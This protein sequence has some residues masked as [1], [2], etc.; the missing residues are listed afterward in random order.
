MKYPLVIFFVLITMGSSAQF[1]KHSLTTKTDSIYSKILKENRMVWIHLPEKASPDQRYPVI[2]VLD[3]DAQTFFIL[4]ALEKNA[5]RD[6]K[7]PQYIVIGIGNISS[8]ERDYTPTHITSSSYMDAASLKNSGGGKQFISFMEKELI[9]YVEA[10]YK[11]SQK[12]ILVG[13]SLGGLAVIDVL[14][15]HTGLF[16]QYIAIDPSLW[17]DNSKLLQQAQTTLAKNNFKD[18]T[19]YLGLSNSLSTRESLAKMKSSNGEKYG[20]VRPGLL[21][22]DHLDSNRQNN[23]RYKWKYYNNHNHASV[24][25]PAVTEALQFI[26]Q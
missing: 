25:T 8:R 4:D 6:A 1:S 17:W 7:F 18:V 14:L 3:G 22:T 26:N 15:N 10:K 16:N 11:V 9:P 5:G 12:R 23:L 24:F 19:L 2:Y 21:L 20:L 13:H